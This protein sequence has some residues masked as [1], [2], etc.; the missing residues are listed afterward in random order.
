MPTWLQCISCFGT[1]AV[2]LVAIAHI[3]FFVA[4]FFGG[5]KLAK[6]PQ[7]YDLPEDAATKMAAVLKNAGFFNLGVAIGLAN[8][9]YSGEFRSTV[10]FLSFAIAAGFVGFKTLPPKV[11]IKSLLLQTALGTVALL[12]VIAGRQ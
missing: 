11:G 6:D 3:V 8:S 4:E 9:F 10:F 12:L 5:K 1:A 2:V 7:V